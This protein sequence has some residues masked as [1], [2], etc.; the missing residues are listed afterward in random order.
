MTRTGPAPRAAG[1]PRGRHTRR[2]GRARHG[3]Q[4]AEPVPRTGP[5]LSI[6]PARASART[7]SDPRAGQRRA[8][9][10]GPSRGQARA[11]AR[12]RGHRPGVPG[13]GRTERPGSLVPA[14]PGLL[15]IGP[16]ARPARNR[17]CRDAPACVPER[18]TLKAG[19]RAP[20]PCGGDTH[21]R[22]GSATSRR[23]ALPRPAGAQSGADVQ[24][25]PGVPECDLLLDAPGDVPPSEASPRRP[26]CLR[27]DNRP[28]TGPGPRPSRT[29]PAPAA[30][31]GRTHSS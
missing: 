22:G 13:H 16:A 17:R 8:R 28:R 12:P 15:G 10:G 25:P 26:C 30:R 20:E 7:R 11:G 9:A 18:W 3:A 29:A 6:S 24:K 19:L 4:A 27:R 21:I 5:D 1:H 2:R 23:S 31:R 14:S